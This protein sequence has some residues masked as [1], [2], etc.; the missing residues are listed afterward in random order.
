MSS[1]ELPTAGVKQTWRVVRDCGRDQAGAAWVAAVCLVLSSASVLVVP[2]LVGR[3]VDIVTGSGDRGLLGPAAFGALVMT[4]VGAVLAAVGAGL[5]AR[6]CENALGR[7]RE[8]ALAAVVALPLPTVERLGRGTVLSRTVG[9]VGVASDVARGALPAFLSALLTLLVTCGG[10]LA[11]DW[12]LAL[13]G[14]LPLPVWVAATRGYLRRS[15]PQYAH[16]RTAEAR[17]SQFLLTGIS[18][19]RTLR[20]LCL[21]DAHTAV[22]KERSEAWSAAALRTCVTRVRFSLH[23]NGAEL[24]GLLAVLVTGSALVR[25]GSLSLGAASTAVLLLMRVF[26]P[27]GT[28][29]YLLDEVQSASAALARLAGVVTERT[30]DAERGENAERGEDA[31]DAVRSGR[32]LPSDGGLTVRGLEFGYADGAPAVQ[33]VTFRVEPGERVAVVGPSGAGK[34]TVVGL[35]T[36]VHTPWRGSVT[37]GG[38]P[39]G[40]LHPRATGLVTQESHVF[41]GS[42]RDNLSIARPD[43]DEPAMTAALA[44]VGALDWALELPEGLETV[45]GPGGEALSPARRQQLALARLVLADPPLAVLDEPTAESYGGDRSAMRT[46]VD[47]ALKGRTG[48]VI[49]HRLSDAR[50]AD[51]ILVLDEGRVAAFG[52]HEQLLRDGGLYAELWSTWTAPRDAAGRTGRAGW[53]GWTGR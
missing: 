50:A 46:A 42:V 3:I 21:E 26:E 25:S 48:I 22:I 8:R 1:E 23:L 35:V 49:A 10:L 43:A 2:L 47:A 4:A 41:A 7:L 12:R 53:T 36:G 24:L 39:I 34:S 28:L 38:V 33:D 15:G 31:E 20:A 32:E 30:G 29:L 45:V 6:V 19:A 18:G 17:L 16:E 51:R 27:V 11:L 37:V 5:T 52:T 40:R 14:A 9:D 44:Q 13:A